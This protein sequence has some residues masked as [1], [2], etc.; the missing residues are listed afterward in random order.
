MTKAYTN[1]KATRKC[2]EIL[3]D[4]DITRCENCGSNFMLTIAHRKKRRHY[5]LEQE[6]LWDFNEF[7]LLC[8]K[9][10]DDI[11]YSRDKTEEIF[12]RLRQ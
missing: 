11:E 6:K 2:K 1:A 9:C 10:H 8:V 3:I 5:N 12:A 4:K 7:L